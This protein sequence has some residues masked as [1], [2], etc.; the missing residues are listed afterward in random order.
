MSCNNT[1]VLEQ[2]PGMVN[3]KMVDDNDLVFGVDWD[4]DITGYLWEAY[5]IPED[6]SDE[7]GL[8]TEV[9]S[10]SAGKMNVIISASSIADISPSVNNWYLNW[11]TPAP[12]SY[13]RTV[14]NGK[15]ALYSKAR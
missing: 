11:T 10:A 14:L 2:L 13:V 9:T 4:I 8:G 12:D 6:G 3:I 7:I 1:G 5:I 15:I